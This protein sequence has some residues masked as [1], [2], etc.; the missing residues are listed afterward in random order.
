MNAADFHISFI[1]PVLLAVIIASAIGCAIIAQLAKR[2]A[3]LREPFS[4]P[5][6]WRVQ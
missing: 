5:D 1:L 2:R 6:D 3:N 4:T